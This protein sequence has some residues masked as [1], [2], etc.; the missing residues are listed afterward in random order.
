MSCSDT[1]FS[2]SLSAYSKKRWDA[3]GGNTADILHSAESWFLSNEALFLCCFF[4]LVWRIPFDNPIIDAWEFPGAVFLFLF[5][6]ASWMSGGAAAA[7]VFLHTC[8]LSGLYGRRWWWWG[9]WWPEC[10]GLCSASTSTVFSPPPPPPPL[11]WALCV[12]RQSKWGENGSST[13]PSGSSTCLR[14]RY[15]RE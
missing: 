13:L 2:V 14:R 11:S 9:W 8:S 5:P 4:S 3:T 1:V 6:K 10:T 12:C 15:P 7:G